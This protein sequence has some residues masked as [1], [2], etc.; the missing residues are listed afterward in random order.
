MIQPQNLRI[1]S[2]LNYDTGEGIEPTRIDW[3]DLKWASEHNLDFNSH[4]SPIELTEDVLMACGFSDADYKDGYIGTEFRSGNGV[5][6]DFVLTKPFV[7]G[8][9]NKTYTFDLPEHRFTEIPYLHELQDLFRIL[10]GKELQIDLEKL[11][12]TK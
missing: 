5:I 1:G 8:E 12:Q 2:V 9:W 10:T 3:Q 6:L 11:N 4:H 7:K